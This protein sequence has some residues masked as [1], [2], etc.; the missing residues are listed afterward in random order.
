MD[1]HDKGSLLKEFGSWPEFVDRIEP[2]VWHQPVGEGKWAVRDVVS[3]I[4]LWDQYFYERAIEPIAEGRPLT[5][6]QPD[7]DLF[8]QEARKFAETK[9]DQELAGLAKEIR[10]RIIIAI[11]EQPDEIF[12]KTY[13]NGQAMAFVTKDY[14]NDFI[15]HDRHHMKQVSD[16]ANRQ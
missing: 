2:S 1:N 14:L 9:S 16:L 3:H 11:Q 4:L 10:R 12:N 5:V 7:F 6:K 13:R 15:W 8:N